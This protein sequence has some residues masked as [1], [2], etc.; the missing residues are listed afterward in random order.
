MKHII[1]N[2]NKVSASKDILIVN[3][4]SILIVAPC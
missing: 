4:N 2:D 1:A 3:V